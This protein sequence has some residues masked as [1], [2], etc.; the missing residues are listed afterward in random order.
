MLAQRGNQKFIINRLNLI[1]NKFCN[2]ASAG[3]GSTLPDPIDV[4]ATPI[5]ATGTVQEPHTQQQSDPENDYPDTCNVLANP[6]A[7]TNAAGFDTVSPTTQPPSLV[8]PTGNNPDA[9]IPLAPDVG[10]LHSNVD[11]GAAGNAAV[12]ATQQ[13]SDDDSELIIDI[14]NKTKETKQVGSSSA[15]Q[16][17]KAKK[18]VYD[19]INRPAHRT[20]IPKKKFTWG[21]KKKTIAIK[22][23]KTKPGQNK[24]PPSTGPNDHTSPLPANSP[25]PS[26]NSGPS[27]LAR[28]IGRR[29]FRHFNCKDPT[30]KVHLDPTT[31]TIFDSVYYQN[32]QKNM[33][34]LEAEQKLIV[35]SRT[36]P[37][38]RSL[39]N[40]P[41]LFYMQFRAAM[42]K[43]SKT[44]VLTKDEGEV[45]LNC[46]AVN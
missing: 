34:L 9:V 29:F 11:V 5:S 1:R 19:P 26:K 37:L 20:H 8:S 12:A 45:R 6:D 32:L 24:T 14:I 44:L 36:G 30:K 7:G 39:A 33:S 28:G 4:R 15:P 41:D 22:L 42:I 40:Q 23:P 3:V 31:P 13:D 17:P 38:V 21:R 35:D 16:P 46:S 2:F 10:G 43:L 18:W 27:R 25:L